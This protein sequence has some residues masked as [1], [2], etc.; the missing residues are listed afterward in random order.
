M[1]AG[2]TEIYA[3]DSERL[4][5]TTNPA[6]GWTALSVP[7]TG[8]AQLTLLA[9]AAPQGQPY[10]LIGMDQ[11]QLYLSPDRGE[12]WQAL[13][14]PPEGGIALQAVFKE[15]TEGASPE[16]Y[17][18]TGTELEPGR[19]RVQLDLLT[20]PDLQQYYGFDWQLIGNL[21]IDLLVVVLEPLF[22]LEASVKLIVAVVSTSAPLCGRRCW[23]D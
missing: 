16:L 3:A 8:E 19:Y 11:G 6:Q 22:G 10:V 12:S 17:L 14:S 7:L 5:R 2:G 1:A 9:L 4:Y 20:S 23:R 18:I 13:D 15:R 21:G